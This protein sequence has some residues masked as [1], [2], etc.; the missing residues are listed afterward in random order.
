M[1]FVYEV[2][3]LIFSRGREEAFPTNTQRDTDTCTQRHTR[4]ELVKSGDELRF[5]ALTEL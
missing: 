5:K 4:T 3:E 2:K 1:V